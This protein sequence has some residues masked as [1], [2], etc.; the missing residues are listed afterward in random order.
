MHNC[1]AE[2]CVRGKLDIVCKIIPFTRSS[3]DDVFHLVIQEALPDR[4]N[5]RHQN[6]YGGDYNRRKKQ[7]KRK[8]QI[9]LFPRHL[10]DVFFV[11]P[12]ICVPKFFNY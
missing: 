2:L 8:P 12:L 3:G 4:I 10:P 1:R 11:R 7:K 5:D 9:P 6:E